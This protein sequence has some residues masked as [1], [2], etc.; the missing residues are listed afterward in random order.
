MNNACPGCGAI[1]AV[2]AKDVGRKLKCKKCSMALV[3]TDDGL[4]ADTPAV[5]VPATPADEFDTGDEGVAVSKKKARRYGEGGGPKFAE[6]IAKVGGIP[7]IL[8]SVGVFLV[9]W[10]TFMDPISQAAIERAEVAEAKVRLEQQAE[11][12]KLLPKGKTSPAELEGDERKNF[13]D[14]AKKINEDYNK[15]AEEAKE[16]AAMSS[17]DVIRGK[18]FD[19]YGQMFGFIFLAFGCIGYL[20]TE[21]PLVL[22]IVAA[23]VLGVM[24][25]VMFGKFG[26]CTGLR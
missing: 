4:V 13:E 3:V 9:L 2:T 21:Q 8:F 10:F 22:K 24:L 5:A 25:I 23:V 15:R 18:R 19:K 16:D 1:Y 20:R 11:L 17:V 14:K 12:K 7:T 26:G 6:M